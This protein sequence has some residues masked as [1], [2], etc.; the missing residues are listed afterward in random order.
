MNILMQEMQQKT[1]F[2]NDFCDNYLELVKNR[3]YGNEGDAAA[4]MS[5]V[6][7]IYH[8]LNGILRLFAPFVPHVTEELFSYI[9]DEDYAKHGSIHA[10]HMWP[11]ADDYPCD[12]DAEGAGIDCVSLLEAVRKQK[13]ERNVS[14]K[15]PVEEIAVEVQQIYAQEAMLKE[16]FADLKGAS[17]AAKVHLGV[18]QG[19]TPSRT[20]TTATED[21]KFTLGILFAAQSDVA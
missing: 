12:A 19:D 21:N 3:V 14:I 1:F 7:T 18:M 2:W 16:T 6:H 5:A 11:Q 4:Q 13:S 15:Y 10:R 17:N 20:A 8:C 9:F